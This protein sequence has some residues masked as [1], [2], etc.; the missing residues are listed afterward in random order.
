MPYTE[1]YKNEIINVI[2]GLCS[3]GKKYRRKVHTL[4]M[5]INFYSSKM[6]YKYQIMGNDILTKMHNHIVTI[7]QNI[8]NNTSYEILEF[9]INIIKW[10]FKQLIKNKTQKNNET[11]TN[12]ITDNNLPDYTIPEIKEFYSSIITN[13]H[14]H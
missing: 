1:E 4:D 7:F 3:D 9:A 10:Y 5:I 12:N 13:N 14:Q 8:N 6:Q 11:T 2:Q